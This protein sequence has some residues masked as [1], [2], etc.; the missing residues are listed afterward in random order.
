MTS[1]PRVIVVP[2]PEASVEA[3][4]L[5]R[6]SPPANL[7]LLGIVDPAAEFISTKPR[8]AFPQ[9]QPFWV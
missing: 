6:D 5:V 7:G 8:L 1:E 3:T 2:V 9:R 4:L